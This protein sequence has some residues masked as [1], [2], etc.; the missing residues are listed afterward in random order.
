MMITYKFR[1]N[2]IVYCYDWCLDGSRDHVLISYR[3][4]C[5]M[6]GSSQFL[7]FETS[8]FKKDNTLAVPIIAVRYAYLN[9]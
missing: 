5:N 1:Y 9:T 6:I 4:S 7:C 8:R 2:N 3:D